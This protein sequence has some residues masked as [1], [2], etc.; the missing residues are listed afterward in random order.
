MVSLRLEVGLRRR[1]KIWSLSLKT[2]RRS[3]ADLPTS[4]QGQTALQTQTPK[5]RRYSNEGLYHPDWGKSDDELVDVYVREGDP[6]VELLAERLAKR[7]SS[8]DQN[9]KDADL[10]GQNQKEAEQMIEALEVEI[11]ELETMVDTANHFESTNKA[12]YRKMC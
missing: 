2:S 10:A 8:E 9:A 4:F 6:L 3:K 5:F 11:R 7:V 12:K 1:L